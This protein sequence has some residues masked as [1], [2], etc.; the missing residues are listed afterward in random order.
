MRKGTIGDPYSTT[1]ADTCATLLIAAGRHPKEIQARVGRARLRDEVTAHL[2]KPR[3]TERSPGGA[4]PV[5]LALALLLLAI[6]VVGCGGG[7]S[8]ASRPRG[9]PPLTVQDL[10]NGRPVDLAQLTP[11]RRPVALWLWGPGCAICQSSATA[12]DRFAGRERERVDVI[13]LGSHGSPESAPRFVREHDMRSMRVLWDQDS[14]AWDELRVP[15][16]PVVIVFDRSGREVDR[17]F[18]P[19]DEG[20][21]LRAA[22]Q[23]S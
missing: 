10:A 19:F 9:L 2:P 23:A 11:A 4:A 17:W 6:M 22:A 12:V 3:P 20:R 15:A 8:D 13:G 21:V 7:P 5:A 1:C 18:G 16:E 14:Y